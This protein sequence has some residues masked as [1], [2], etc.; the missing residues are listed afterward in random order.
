MNKKDTIKSRIAAYQAAMAEAGVDAA[1]LPR[2]DA[3]LSEY[4]S[5]YWHI[6]RYLSGFTGSAATLVITADRALLW[7]DSRY[8]LQAG[9]Q[10]E[11]TGIELMKDGLPETPS[12]YDWLLAN[13]HGGQT[14]GINGMLIS[15]NEAAELRSLLNTKGI[16]LDVEFDPIDKIW[17][18]RP[19]LPD[20]KAFVHD[21]KY[22]GE[23]AQQRM[24]RVLD[25]VKAKGA[26]SFFT[27]A[28]DEIAWTLN[29][30]S[31]DVP[32]NLPVATSFLYLAPK[33]SVL[34][35]SEAK[36]TPEVNAHLK[37][38]GVETKPYTDVVAFLKS[39][40]ADNKVMISGS[41]TSAGMAAALEGHY[42]KADSP[43][44]MFKAV[45]NETQM[46]GVRE[47]H[48]RD[49]VAMVRSIKEIKDIINSGKPL[50]EIE[51]ADILEKNRRKMPLFFDLSFDTISGWAEHG[52][53]VH[54]SPTAESNAAIM[55]DGLLLL[56]SGA[57]YLDATTDITRT[58]AIGMPSYEMC[59]DFTLV[60]KGHIAIA[61]S[62]FPEGTTGHQLD[63]FAR[64]PLWKEGKSYLHGTGHGVGLF[65]SVHEG[66][67]SIRLNDT[68]APLTPGML[69]SNEPGIYI[70]GEYG[71]R[72]ENL[73][74]TVPYEETEFGKFYAFETVTLCPFDRCL[75]D[76][77]L[78]SDDEV[79]WVDDY[80][81]HVYELLAP[82]LTTEE[83]QWLKN[84][85][86]PLRYYEDIPF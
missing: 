9:E 14:V 43:I 70:T 17:T 7:T 42:V 56:D 3:H 53:I 25:A 16:K 29:I 27:S 8:F 21:V 1:I 13:L 80:H 69:T 20:G 26:D 62:I 58:I 33:G 34:F 64:M 38:I 37:E 52:A 48:I 19:A 18:D 82:H 71:I 76:V 12:I 15:V 2:T 85:T 28:L 63:A 10:L 4:I 66:P 31:N 41:R 6:V 57:N 86:E 24:A 46:I 73:V 5:A 36:L 67:Q 55:G 84:E 72:C 79:K 59:H 60:M 78:M 47:A 50:T 32:H 77:T 51:A 40:P 83:R 61:T 22:T 68:H 65:L 74:L 30:R 75:F 45:K 23:S 11:G 39:L 81:R 49:G 44:M 54:Y 35:I